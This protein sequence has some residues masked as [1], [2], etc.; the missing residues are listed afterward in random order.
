MNKKHL[1]IVGISAILVLSSIFIYLKIENEKIITSGEITKDATWYGEITLTGDIIVRAGVTLT[2]MPGTV[3]NVQ[4]GSDESNIGQLGPMDDLLT[5]DPTYDANAGGEEY[6]KT[7]IQIQV[8]G[9]IISKGTPEKPADPHYT[10]WQGIYVNYGEFEYTKISHSIRGIVASPNFERLTVDHCH[11]NNIWAAG[12]GYNNPKDPETRSFVKHST[13][14]DCGHEAIDTHSTGHLEV[15]YNVIKNSQVG[16]NLHDKI[17]AN[18]HHNLILNTTFPIIAI[19]AS[20]AFV[21]QCTFVNVVGQDTSRW[22]Y[23][24]WTMPRFANACGIFAASQYVSN[25]TVTNS[26]IK[27]APC[28]MRIENPSSVITMGYINFEDVSVDF[29]DGITAGAGIYH[30]NCGFEDNILFKLSNDSPLKGKGNPEDGNPDLGA[31]GGD[32]AENVLGW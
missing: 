22:K 26:I 20:F 9:R 25:I 5:G 12:I 11:I 13:I 14:E 32:N 19:D 17:D 15:A 16:V 31:Y 24:G 10:D 30:L 21:T 4:V 27:N 2:V 7:H 18:T 6:I 29:D 23:K 3:I 8:D 28:G 1:Y